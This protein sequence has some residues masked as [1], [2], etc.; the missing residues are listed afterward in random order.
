MPQTSK[1]TKSA[2]LRICLGFARVTPPI[3]RT[4]R[5]DFRHR[6]AQIRR[7]AL[8]PQ[9]ISTYGCLKCLNELFDGASLPC[10][11]LRPLA[12]ILS[13]WT[14]ILLPLPK[15]ARARFLRVPPWSKWS[16]KLTPTLRAL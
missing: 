7:L 6:P 15:Q 1:G 4:A 3:V 16:R 12:A 11:Y 10:L 9:V 5:C 14:L 8:M 13:L 2:L